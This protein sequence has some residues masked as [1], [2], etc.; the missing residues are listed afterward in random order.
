MTTSDETELRDLLDTARI[1]R[2]FDSY[3]RALDEKQFDLSRFE[4]IFTS[5]AK[6]VRPNGVAMTG[7]ETIAHSHA[8]SF[9]RFEGSQHL[10]TGHHV[11]IDGDTATLRANMVAIHLWKDMPA[12]ASMLDRSFT[13]GGVITAELLRTPD[14]WRIAQVANRIL[15]RTGY[16]GNIAQ[17]R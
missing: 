17:T 8:D 15:W 1:T 13:A 5:D 12:G 16:S 4:R 9:T 11:E 6:V 3:F 2:V 10:L 7:P 14:G